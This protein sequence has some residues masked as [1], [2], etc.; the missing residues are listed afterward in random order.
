MKST[1]KPNWTEVTRVFEAALETL[2]EEREAFLER[3]CA[4]NADLRRE[5][6]S[7]LEADAQA[8]HFMETLGEE[9]IPTSA[10]TALAVD[11]FA[12]RVLS[13]YR[14]E[15][16]LGVGG[17]GTVYRATDLKLGRAVAIKF[18][19][20]HLVTDETAKNRFV[21][22]A[23]AASALDHPNIGTVYDI[24]EE[25]GE[26]FI[27][28]ALYEG[29]TLRQRLDKGR[30]GLDEAV[31]VLRQIALGLEA[32][33]R[34]GIVHRDIKPANILI[35][36]NGTIKILDFGLA[37]IVSDAQARTMTQAGHALGT[38]AYMSP[39]Q[40]RGESVD[41]RSDLWSLGVVAYEVL[42]AVSPFQ[43]DSSA[44]TAM[45]I[46]ND[47]PPSLAT[48]VGVPNRLAELVWQLV[49]K[50]PRE[51]PQ[52]ASEVLLRLEG[53]GKGPQRRWSVPKLLAE[54]KRRRWFRA[55]VVV[56]GT[57]AVL[58]LGAGG[59]HLYTQRG[60][61][62]NPAPIVKSLLVLPFTKAAGSAD[63]EYL[64]DGIAEGLIDS[65]SQL[66]QLR[67]IGRTM[68]FRYKDK[69][70]DFKAL[71]SDL[72]VDAVLNGRVRQVSDALVIQA[73]LVSTVTGAQL[74]GDRYTRKLTDILSLQEEITR[75]IAEKLRPQLAHEVQHRVT[76]RYTDN[77][78][79]YQLYLRGLFFWNKRTK[80]SVAKGLEY[81][82]KAVEVDPN[83]TL[84]LV[85]MADSYLVLAAYGFTPQHEAVAKAD[86]LVTKALAVD[87]ELAEAHATLANVKAAEWNFGEVEREYK[88]AIELNPSYL[89]AHHWYGLYL[90]QMTRF[91]E[92]LAE[93]KRA[94]Y[95]DPASAVV[96]LN[97]IA[98]L[99][100]MG[101]YEQAS[102]ALKDMLEMG[103][104][105]Q[106]A[107]AQMTLCDL[108]RSMYH[109]AIEAL[110]EAIASNPEAPF[111]RGWLGYACALSGRKDDAWN[112]LN[113]LKARDETTDAA[114]EIAAVYSGLGATD[115]A[116]DWLE[117]AFQRRSIR[118]RFL[119]ISPMAPAVV[120]DPRFS[121]L[122]R[123]IGYW[124]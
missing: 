98:T 116:F 61:R 44:A 78:E 115:K 92:A 30:L 7:L 31:G 41:S 58:A 77:P 25:Q 49:R 39:E 81:F 34:A 108:K 35:T 122:V 95:L 43:A 42:T 11:A 2:P 76:K 12:G 16:G 4:G 29:E 18:L 37:K 32:A 48:V 52:A 109:E 47:E 75:A 112:V 121:S 56:F 57:S 102:D 107:R 72:S 68:A 90:E 106:S 50:D 88:R 120:S 9:E 66:P 1:Q 123:R 105:I 63:V 82:S 20:R 97:L 53:P 40:L 62:S 14:L 84:A 55:A 19:A 110:Q 89:F 118:L 24:G 103:G 111:Y 99:C 93:I 22:E 65:F 5:V 15:R 113:S 87:N 94:H 91:D 96:N 71:Q 46:L 86:A 59:V 104:N 74:W 100:L 38:V 28:M 73:D 54:L 124:Q 33:H 119:K 69:E 117:T 10:V 8:G 114:F 45:R 23:R 36:S 21:R 26:L 27:V 83:Y 6:Q 17:M 64:A 3:A 70:S 85:G 13:H 80:E 60:E 79:A 51:R 67:V 101:Q